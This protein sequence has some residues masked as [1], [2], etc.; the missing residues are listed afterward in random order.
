MSQTQYAKGTDFGKILLFKNIINFLLK[1]SENV[2]LFIYTLVN[3]LNVQSLPFKGHIFKYFTKILTK[4]ILAI[5][6][7]QDYPI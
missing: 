6:P 3:S 2:V 1:S 5:F 4:Y 7:L